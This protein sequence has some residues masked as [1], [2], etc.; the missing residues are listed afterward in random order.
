M[1]LIPEQ[2]WP[3]VLLALVLLSDAAMSMRPPKFIRDCLDGVRFPREW[4]WTL[5]VIKTLATA[6]LIVGIWVPGIA[7]AANVGVI[8]YFTCAAASHIRA[9]FFGPAFWLNCLGLLALSVTVLVLSLV[10]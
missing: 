9:R 7:F 6:G 4:W 10:L 2:W 3:P 8:A 5:I 1:I